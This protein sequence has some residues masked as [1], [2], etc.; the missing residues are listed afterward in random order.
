MT[1]RSPVDTMDRGPEPE[2]VPGFHPAVTL[3]RLLVW[4]QNGFRGK[5]GTKSDNQ[6]G[7][8]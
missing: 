5:A 1:A 4:R 2:P 3:A 8:G 7:P 6:R